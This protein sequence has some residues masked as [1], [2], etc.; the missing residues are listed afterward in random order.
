MARSALRIFIF[1]V[2]T[3][4]SVAAVAIA[5]LLGRLAIA[6]LNLD[7]YAPEI[8]AAANSALD[9]WRLE[10]GGAELMLRR[11]EGD[12]ALRLRR[13][14]L[15]EPDGSVVARAPLA[16]V[17]ADLSEALLGRVALTEAS[18]VGASGV[19]TRTESGSYRFAFSATDAAETEAAPPSAL[20]EGAPPLGDDDLQ[21]EMAAAQDDVG[22]QAAAAVIEGL[23]GDRGALPI[24]AKFRRVEILRARLRYFDR[25]GGVAWRSRDAQLTVERTTGGVS[26]L[27]TATAH[28]MGGSRIAGDTPITLTLRGGRRRGADAI[29]L[30]ARFSDVSGAAIAA[31]IS[32]FEM[33]SR[34]DGAFSG[35]AAAR[36]NLA[37]GELLAFAAVVRAADAR[38]ALAPELAPIELAALEARLGYTPAADEF[39]LERLEFDLGEVSGKA[40]GALTIQRGPEG[41]ALGAAG[42]LEFSD[43]RIA[44][45]EIYDPPTTVSRF[46]ASFDFNADP[47]RLRVSDAELEKGSLR[48]R[49]DGELI[50]G[51]DGATKGSAQV[52][53]DGFPATELPALWPRLISA[54][55]RA[56]VAENVWDG[57]IEGATLR[58]DWDE[59]AVAE[60][61]PAADVSATAPV[62][63][64]APDAASEDGVEESADD[65]A[66]DA[67]PLPGV[68]LDFE[69]DFSGLEVQYVRGM[70][71]LTEGVG[72]GRVT[73][74]R[75]EVELASGAVD[76]AEAG[77]ITVD[78]SHF[79]IP[80]L[81][82]DS[83]E[84]GEVSV[85]ASGPAR[86]ILA[87]IDEEPL[88]FPTKFG[89]DVSTVRGA[90]EVSG[91]VSL[92]LLKDLPLA[93]VVVDVD[94]Q[95][96]DVAMI[97]PKIDRPVSAAR[98]RVRADTKRLLLESPR[99]RFEG[100][101]L[102]V[103]WREVFAPDRGQARSRFDLAGRIPATWLAARGAPA[104]LDLEG[105][106][107]FA[108]RLT[109]VD[110][111]TPRLAATVDLTP[112]GLNL[113]PLG[114]R[115]APGGPG[116]VS[117][118]ALIG[119]QRVALRDVD[120][121]LGPLAAAGAVTFGTD[122]QFL[123]AEFSRLST[124]PDT[125]LRGTVTPDRAGFDIDLSGPRIDL[126]PFMARRPSEASERPTPI[127]LRLQAGVARLDA[128]RR[129]TDL[130]VIVERTRG[131]LIADLTARTPLG[132]DIT[133]AYRSRSAGGGELALSSTNAGLF[134]SDMGLTT[135][136]GGGEFRI[137]AEI[138]AAGDAQGT[139]KILDVTLVDPPVLAT[140]ISNATLIGLLDGDGAGGIR[141][142]RVR[143]P[144]QTRGDRVEIDGAAATGP[145]IG[146]TADGRIER[147]AQRLS[148]VGSV[149]PFYAVNS[150]LGRV[151]VL[152]DLL[153]G[154]R[155]EGVVGVAYAVEG[156]LADP[157][158]TVNPLSA[159][160]P[161]ALRGLFEGERQP[162]VVP[163][164]L[165]R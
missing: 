42:A 58:L 52:D 124:G 95:L 92:P 112:L 18:L 76:L 143:I 29:E 136:A 71:P 98:A 13:V 87:L 96:Q 43:V 17:S 111:A 31:Q 109:V 116:Q 102:A 127:S 108:G 44:N 165:R 75:F 30:S 15:R 122:G 2:A 19:L 81:I 62:A 6:P 21:R 138:D 69:F 148:L 85:T 131:R 132:A 146:I 64:G 74:W 130:S 115:K 34:F 82:T 135:E 126:R 7:G 4:F 14:R 125:E 110:Q 68:N 156:P 11:D 93:Q 57:R 161:G 154:G 56:W 113:A 120:L 123:G 48:A 90:A 164:S 139:L 103:T 26:A 16:T 155:G 160:A 159:L 23:A 145:S 24:L 55:A 70:T 144:F 149:S 40:T 67:R 129:V 79:A 38:V 20:A 106:A 72:V 45:P 80:E 142:S 163:P 133:G 94:A 99:L 83:V 77:R 47:I 50:L 27:L 140:I 84:Q 134:L 41:Q 88:G 36:L 25:L 59:S 151:P 104:D 162:H 153:T 53:L 66:A 9:G 54:N 121:A 100:L 152:G 51:A 12:I 97:A 105:A 101:P 28:P 33:A 114:L 119:A 157:T 73:P 3:L 63:V 46:A 117:L 158:V 141:F 8:E 61:R 35:D 118:I 137:D 89:L 107:D 49:G 32:A 39:R 86:A 60:A 1:S 37:G 91:S 128:A 147:A 65:G 5:L 22:A 10:L 78:G 150:L